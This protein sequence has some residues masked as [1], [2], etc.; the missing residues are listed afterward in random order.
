VEKSIFTAF[1][2]Y[3]KRAN[4]QMDDIIKNISEKEWNKQFSSH[5]KSIHELCSHIFFGNYT[6]LNK[7]RLFVAY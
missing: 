2:N 6:W 5:W 7:F 4:D 1:A 3:N